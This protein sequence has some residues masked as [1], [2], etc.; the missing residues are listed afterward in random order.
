M[1]ITSYLPIHINPLGYVRS[2]L[3]L[4]S[5]PEKGDNAAQPKPHLHHHPQQEAELVFQNRW[6]MLL[7]GIE[8]YSHIMVLYWPHLLRA[9]RTQQKKIHPMGRSELPLTGVLATRTPGRPNPVLVTVVKLLKRTENVLHVQGLEAINGSP[10]IDIK[11][12]SLD[13]WANENIQVP[14]W[15]ADLQKQG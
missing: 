11:P 10:I 4:P 6:S 9:G 5:A 8:D 1:A 14:K 12:H 13:Y 15:R 3:E 7:D 2:S